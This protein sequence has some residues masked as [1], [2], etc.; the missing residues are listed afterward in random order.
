MPLQRSHITLLALIVLLS[1]CLRDA[2]PGNYT[3]GSPK[4]EDLI[5]RYVPNQ[6]TLEL[7]KA[8]GKYA[9]S[10]SSITLKAD[11]SVEFLNMPDWWLTTFRDAQGKFDS[12]TGKWTVDRNR[13]FWI[14]VVSF[15]TQSATVSSAV[16]KRGNVTAMLSLV[17][18]KAPY[19]LQMSITDTNADVAMQY[20][21]VK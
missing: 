7:L 8:T 17:G 18:Q 20:Q 4:F 12:A 16:P 15:A 3:L 10:D 1:S 6:E 2:N 19:S 5:G 9:K 21:K 14:V 11:G 13:Q